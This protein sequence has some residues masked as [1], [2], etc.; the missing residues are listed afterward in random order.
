M[1]GYM[2]VLL[3]AMTSMEC[4]ADREAYLGIH[5]YE[6]KDYKSALR[7]F[8]PLANGIDGG[9]ALAQSYLGRMYLN[10]QGVP[11][12]DSQAVDWF[13][14]AAKQGDPGAMSYLGKMYYTG[15]I[16]EV[17][18]DYSQAADFFR[19]AAAQGDAPAQFM[20]GFMYE[21][22]KGVPKN[23]NQAFGLY[24]K[25]AKQGDALA[26][27]YLGL[28]YYNE[29]GGVPRDYSQAAGL[30]RKAAEQGLPDAQ[31]YLGVMYEHG[32]GVK[33]NLVLAH[34]LYNLAA[35][36]G[37]KTAK[38]NRDGITSQLTPAQLNEAKELASKWVK[39][40][41]LPTITKTYPSSSPQEK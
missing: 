2:W 9:D 41:P 32:E 14:K 3:L 6:T 26:Q 22:G 34:M 31:F 23:D 29:K 30:Y 28:M 17:E 36:N 27:Y 7:E 15:D 13:R 37:E 5:Y 12:N 25:A 35:V 24:R 19:K 11:K 20:L 40:Q 8:L 16:V 1:K 10:G 39:G 21:K 33:K 38:D 18:Q 4:V